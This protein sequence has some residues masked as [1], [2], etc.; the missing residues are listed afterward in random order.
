MTTLTPSSVNQADPQIFHQTGTVLDKRK[1][2]YYSK[3][4]K[5]KKIVLSQ[6]STFFSR[7]S[8]SRCTHY[9]KKSIVGTMHIPVMSGRL[10]SFVPARLL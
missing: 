3:N 9:E 5:T 6:Y 8:T 4:M 7:T 10:G 1:K 2:I